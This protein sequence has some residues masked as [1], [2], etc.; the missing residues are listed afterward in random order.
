M[1]SESLK[2]SAKVIRQKPTKHRGILDPTNAAKHFQLNRYLPSSDLASFVEH[3]W[4]IRWD[5]RNHPS[6]TS[7]V[8]PYP[9]INLTFTQDRAWITGV[10]TGKYDYELKGTGVIVGVRFRAGTFYA[11]WSHPMNKLTD[12]TM[13]LDE[14]FPE[15]DDSFRHQFLKFSDDKKIVVYLEEMLLAQEP[16]SNNHM[17][18]ATK[19]VASI[20]ND[21][22]LQTVQAVARKFR[23]NERTLQHLFQTYVGVGV[24][25]VVMRFRLQEAAERIAKGEQNLTTIAA[26][27]D[28]SDQA[29][30][31]RDFKR[32]VGKSP[33]EYMRGLQT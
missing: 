17:Q 2:K 28:Y 16:K 13:P 24:K 30:F 19:I 1:V 25:W 14:V 27:L 29:H 22:E 32:I 15:V 8:L 10:T 7:E 6:Y 4:I 21:R 20:V 23:V 18:L 9:N 31:A 12:K 11:F 26:E 3:Y 5:L 33:S